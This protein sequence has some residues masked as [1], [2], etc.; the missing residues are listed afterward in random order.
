MHISPSYSGWSQPFVNGCNQRR[1]VSISAIQVGGGSVVINATFEKLQTRYL[2]LHLYTSPSVQT[3]EPAR[4][5]EE[6]ETALPEVL[7][8]EPIS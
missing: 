6:G 7:T 5:L 1:Q 2:D 4:G 3:D 8:T